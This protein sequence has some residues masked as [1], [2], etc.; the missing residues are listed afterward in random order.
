[1]AQN[2]FFSFI[3]L[4]HF[5]Q[6]LMKL[7][8]QYKALESTV[9]SLSQK[10]VDLEQKLLSLKNHL[11][12]MQKSVDLQ[13]LEMKELEEKEKNEKEKL[14]QAKNQKE[15]QCLR[16]EVEKISEAEH[17]QESAVVEA[18]NKLENAR[19]DYEKAQNEIAGTLQGIEQ[20]ESEKKQ[21][22][23]ILHEQLDV[24]RGQRKMKE[25]GIDENLIEH[26]DAMRLQVVDPVVPVAD[27]C[28]GSCF[29]QISQSDYLALQKLKL[30]RCKNCYRFL[31]LTELIPSNDRE[32]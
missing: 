28:C 21:Q 16:K 26:Y 7:E 25:Q 24:K 5:D 11:H 9:L 13:E 10:K 20:E 4:V 1:M 2:P 30:L 15:Y 29:Y 3:N 12:D 17:R 27:S 8:K 6:Q 18:W 31:Y 19:R 23:Q 22:L 14:D 32:D